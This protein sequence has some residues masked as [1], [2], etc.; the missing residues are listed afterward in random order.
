VTPIH[1]VIWPVVHDPIP[2]F[3]PKKWCRR[4]LLQTGLFFY[5]L[6]R[7]TAAHFT[8]ELLESELF[9]HKAGSFTEHQRIKKPV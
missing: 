7:S 2:L 6:W 1:A 3:H 8:K 9:G 4:W 5:R